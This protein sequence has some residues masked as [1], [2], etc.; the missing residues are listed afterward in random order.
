VILGHLRRRRLVSLLAAGVLEGREKDDA[1][2]HVEACA[3]CRRDLEELRA[4][5]AAMEADPVREAEPDVPVAFLVARVEREIEQALVPSGRPRWW[6]VALPAA[7]AILAVAVLVPS[8]V[9]R[10]RPAPAAARAAI[11][12]AEA[13]PLVTEDALARIERNLAREHAARYQSEAGEVLVA[14]AATGVDCDRTEERLDVGR[15]P[16]RSRELLGRRAL[17]QAGGEAVASARGVLDDVELALREVADLPSCV[18]R[19]DVERLRQEVERR[20][21]LMR[22]RLMTRELEG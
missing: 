2:A 6:L 13:S 7:A 14:V 1:L 20:Q 8:L 5:V 9:A 3:R 4:L 19:T 12:P 11:P 17:V 21:L 18:K 15:A 16:E 22:I 10:L